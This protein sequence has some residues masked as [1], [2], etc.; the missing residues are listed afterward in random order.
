MAFGKRLRSPFWRESVDREVDDELQFHVE[1]RTRELIARG[2]DAASARQAALQR[3]GDIKRV[4]ATCRHIGRQRDRDMRRTEYLSELIQD[5]TFAC[6]QLLKNP[7][8]S[9]VAITDARAG[10]RRDHR[11][12]QRRTRRRPAAAAGAGAG[13]DPRHLRGLPRQQR[14]CVGRELRR[15][16][17]AGV[18]LQRRHRHPVFRASIWRRRNPPSASSAPARPRGS[19]ACSG[20]IQN[21][22]VS[23]R[24]TKISPGAIRWS[25]SA[26]GC[27]AGSLQAIPPSSAGS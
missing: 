21:V 1:M 14:K 5:V 13:T 18:E 9:I 16:R 11:D 23:T 19:F 17:S 7:A 22:V 20:P 10:N 25:C 27:G 12:L 15:W 26:I 4:N 3:F 24:R 6:R 8:F 2:I